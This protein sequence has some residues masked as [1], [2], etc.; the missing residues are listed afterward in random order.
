MTF[1]V[2]EF[3][4]VSVEGRHCKFQLSTGCGKIGV[5]KVDGVIPMTLQSIDDP[6][7]FVGFYVAA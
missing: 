1:D 5:C 2:F 7:S 4:Q 3:I 6:I